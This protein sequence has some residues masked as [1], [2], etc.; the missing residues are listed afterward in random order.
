MAEMYKCMECGH[1]FDED[2]AGSAREWIGEDRYESNS[3]GWLY[4]I[5]CP[6]CGSTEMVEAECCDDCGEYFDE[7]DLIKVGDMKLCRECA[8]VYFEAYWERWGYAEKTDVD[9]AKKVIKMNTIPNASG[10]KN[11]QRVMDKSVF[12]RASE[13]HIPKN[14]IYKALEEMGFKQV[15]DPIT[16]INSWQK[17]ELDN[18]SI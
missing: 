7:T 2:E 1:V 18:G 15:Y 6:E 17:G 16:K 12:R 8:M 3:S 14:A 11:L 9:R 4:Y 5:A 13:I 10:Y